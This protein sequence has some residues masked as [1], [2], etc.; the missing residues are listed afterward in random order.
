MCIL[1]YSPVSGV[2]VRITGVSSNSI[3]DIPR[4][5]RR[6]FVQRQ[7]FAAGDGFALTYAWACFRIKE[8]LCSRVIMIVDSVG[9][10]KLII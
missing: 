8:G 2:C 4:G 10:R 1:E 9:I 6:V 5:I 3:K 7:N